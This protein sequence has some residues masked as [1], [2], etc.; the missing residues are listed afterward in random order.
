[1]KLFL[2]FLLFMLYDT[3]LSAFPSAFYLSLFTNLVILSIMLTDTFLFICLSIIVFLNCLSLSTC[4][5]VHL[6]D[7]L[8]IIFII[9]YHFLIKI[10]FSS[11]SGK[12]FEDGGERETESE[13]TERQTERKIWSLMNDQF[14]SDTVIDN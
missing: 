8:T 12:R 14:E 5:F 3:F 2:L 1:M 4:S 9:I 10:F 13:Q 7:C 6:S 11:F